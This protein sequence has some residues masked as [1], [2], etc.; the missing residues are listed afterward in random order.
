MRLWHQD[1]L[2]HLPA[3]QLNGQHREC[4]ALRGLGWGRP[5]ST[6][7]YVFTH[8]PARLSKYHML[9][10]QEK[11]RRGPSWVDHRWFNPL[12]R[13]NRAEPWDLH[14]F[15][16]NWYEHSEGLIYP[17]HNDA[18]FAEC[19]ANLQAKGATL[20]DWPKNG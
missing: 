13:G 16:M 15:D 12:F 9:V 20:Y 2:P 7:N 5:H 4:C 3:Q 19:L 14:R 1:L 18:Y 8:N 17:E 6:V 10:M 11:R